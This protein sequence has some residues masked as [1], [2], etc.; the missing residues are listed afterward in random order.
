MIAASLS[1]LLAMQASPAATE[2]GADETC[3]QPVY[4][5]V[6]GRTLDRARMGQYAQAIAES[7]IYQ[8]LGGYYVTLPR[9][10]ATFEGELL[11]NYVNLTVR[12]PCL[13]NAEAFWNSDVYQN[14]ILPIR[15]NPSAGDYTVTVY[16][17]A[18]LRE[19]MLGKV[20]AAD[21]LAEFDGSRVPDPVRFAD[22]KDL[23]LGIDADTLEAPEYVEGWATRAA[24]RFSSNGSYA[25]RV[26]IIS[27]ETKTFDAVGK[28]YQM[29]VIAGELRVAGHTLNPGDF[30]RMPKGSI[31]GDVSA[32][33]GTTYLLFGD[34]ADSLE[35][36][37]LVPLVVRGNEVEWRVG[38]V[39][40]EGGAEAPLMIKPLWTD[41]KT[42]ARAH[43]VKIAPGVSVP[44]EIHP[45]AEEGYLLEGDYKLAECLPSGRRDYTYDEG[46]YFYRPGG[47]MHSGP[48]SMTST[49]ATWLIRTPAEL[50][51]LFYP[52]CPAAPSPEESTP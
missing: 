25:V 29:Y 46:G 36:Y 41:P 33:P 27:D 42:G 24:L 17:E 52:S 22:P 23:V 16:S 3:N 26:T 7:G 48:D 39:A 12:F 51:A 2:A 44:W 28:D 5:V 45:S 20:G 18:A 30:I 35:N 6:E 9:P 13:R 15:L 11:D 31:M 34:P 4:M 32:T 10:I 21:Y 49:G 1:A 37:N 40:A 8:R 43:L 38:T 50:T 19:D 47:V 14:E